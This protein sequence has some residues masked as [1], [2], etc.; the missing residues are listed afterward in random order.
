MPNRKTTLTR[1]NLGFGPDTVRGNPT[2]EPQIEICKRINQIFC[3]LLA[4][5]IDVNI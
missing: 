4:P 3:L 2:K 1:G 5:D